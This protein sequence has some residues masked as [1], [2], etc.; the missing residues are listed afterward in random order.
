M[1]IEPTE[2]ESKDSM[3]RFITVMKDIAN[4]AKTRPDAEAHFHSFPHST[5][6]RRL[7]E[8]KAARQP[9]LRWT[10]DIQ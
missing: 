6:R 5:P 3:D 10:E 2:T 8:V 7:D 9:I 1:L 4:E